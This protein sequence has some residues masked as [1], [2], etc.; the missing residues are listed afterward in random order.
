MRNE[1]REELTPF[2][3]SMAH[4]LPTFCGLRICRSSEVDSPEAGA[5]S[6]EARWGAAAASSGTYWPRSAPLADAAEP[7]ER[8]EPAGGSVPRPRDSG[9][10][11]AAEGYFADVAFPDVTFPAVPALVAAI[12]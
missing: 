7:A 5:R 3:P 11:L 1:R 9:I 10:P 6:P 12:L 2:P 4:W 8:D